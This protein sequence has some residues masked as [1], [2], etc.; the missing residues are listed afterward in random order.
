MLVGDRC[1]VEACCAIQ[2]HFDAHELPL[3]FTGTGYI[4]TEDMRRILHSLGMRMSYRQVKDLC[5]L[6]AEITGSSSRS[7]TDRVYYRQLTDKVEV[8]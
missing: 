6:V 2:S 8:V 4:K 5:S 7:R 3:L 1:A